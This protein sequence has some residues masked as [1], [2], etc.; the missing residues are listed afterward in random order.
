MGALTSNRKRGDEWL[1][2]NH[3]HPAVTSP[4]SHVSKKPRLSSMQQTPDRQVSWSKSAVARVSRYPEA[5]PPLR[6]VHAPCRTVKFASSPTTW[7]RDSS[8]KKV[9][10]DHMG[11][12]LSRR[13]WAA[14]DAAL[15]VC[16]FLS[17]HE[18][19]T[20]LDTEVETDRASEDS[21]TEEIEV[22]EEDG[23]E[24]LPVILDQRP[25]QANGVVASV[26]QMDAKM[27]VRST[28]QPSS[29]VVPN[30]TVKVENAEKMLDLLSL[31]REHKAGDFPY[32][33]MLESAEKRNPKLRQLDFEIKAAEKRRSFFEWL[34]PKR[35]PLEV[36]CLLFFWVL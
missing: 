19:E 33:K 35:K 26:D 13:F 23:R 29:S 4:N 30:A 18:E 34:L 2:S 9:V 27:V 16:Q 21:G 22:L 8:A 31:N 1:S 25:R 7:N 6:R 24:G 20:E 10:V 36:K 3:A 32:K 11:N 15:G 17:K 14:K 5:K 12:S 28:K